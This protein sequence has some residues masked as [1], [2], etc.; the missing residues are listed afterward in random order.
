[1]IS[2]KQ[3]TAIRLK[4]VREKEGL[5]QEKFAAIIGLSRVKL[6]KVEAGITKPSIEILRAVTNK[7]NV[8]YEF[9]LGMEET[10]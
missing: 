10:E 4:E 1:M 9:L 6:A 3:T 7:F 2:I 5:T 8:T